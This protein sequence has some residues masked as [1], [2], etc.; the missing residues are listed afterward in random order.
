[1]VITQSLAPAKELAKHQ[2]RYPETRPVLRKR[3]DSDQVEGVVLPDHR[4]E[5]AHATDCFRRP[6]KQQESRGHSV[7]ELFQ[8]QRQIIFRVLRPGDHHG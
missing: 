5:Q 4:E 1:M 6:P 7:G 3:S 2:F 8:L